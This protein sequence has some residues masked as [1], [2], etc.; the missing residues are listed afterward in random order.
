M[1]TPP[2]PRDLLTCAI[3][4]LV[5]AAGHGVARRRRWFGWVTIIAL[6]G[7]TLYRA[8]PAPLHSP[9]EVLVQVQASAF[10]VVATLALAIAGVVA[11]M[12]RTGRNREP[13][14]R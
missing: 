14:A 5:A 12:W 9:P 11:G 10:W 4:V 7:V 6:L 13:N 1:F 2:D 8:E 3:L